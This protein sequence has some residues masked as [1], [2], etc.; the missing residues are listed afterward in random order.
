MLKIHAV[1]YVIRYLFP[2]TFILYFVAYKVKYNIHYD[3]FV[4]IMGHKKNISDLFVSLMTSYKFFT[5]LS[6]KAEIIGSKKAA[7]ILP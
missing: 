2:I 3:T 4:G 6:R 1:L 5:H 7:K